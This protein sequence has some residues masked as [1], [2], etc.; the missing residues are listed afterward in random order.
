MK[1]LRVLR[2]TMKRQSGQYALLMALATQKALSNLMK[3]IRMYVMEIQVLQA[4]KMAAQRKRTP[5]N[6]RIR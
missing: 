2:Q 4:N 6:R 3:R 1:Q 5:L